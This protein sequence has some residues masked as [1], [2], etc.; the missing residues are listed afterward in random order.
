MAPLHL[1]QNAASILEQAYNGEVNGCVFDKWLIY[2]AVPGLP[3]GEARDLYRMGMKAYNEH[4]LGEPESEGEELGFLKAAELI[5]P[6]PK[7]LQSILDYH[8]SMVEGQYSGGA[9]KDQQ[10]VY[11]FGFIAITSPD[12][13]DNGVTAT[14]C[15]KDR[16]QWK[17]TQCSGMPIN[18]L[19]LELSSVSELDVE[20]DRV[21]EQYDKGSDNS[22][23]DN[24]GGPAP[25]GEWQF[26]VFCNRIWQSKAEDL[27]PDPRGCASYSLGEGCLWF[28]SP[29]EMSTEELLQDW[30]LMYAKAVRDPTIPANGQVR[31]CV[32]HPSL[33]VVVEGCGLQYVKIVIM[34]WDRKIQRCDAELHRV[35]QESQL[36]VQNCDLA[37]VVST[38]EHLATKGW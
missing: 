7:D 36:D 29:S 31:P 28:L 17:V 32:W 9:P 1:P 38:L 11:R 19:G 12:W 2:I 20:F 33:F 13:R 8:L 10:H 21:R 24:V 35:G 34:K 37:C 4:S 27:I 23:P 26:A 6:P 16:G 5:H 22:G 18:Q 14:H 25:L 3:D 30:P 15:D